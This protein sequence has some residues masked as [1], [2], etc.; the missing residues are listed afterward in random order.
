MVTHDRPKVVIAGWQEMA[1]PTLPMM[2]PESFGAYW[3]VSKTTIAQI[4]KCDRTTVI[5][6]IARHKKD[7]T[8]NQGIWLTLGLINVVWQRQ[9][10]QQSQGVAA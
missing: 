8:I 4:C 1:I 5:R 9:Q 10:R 3:N 6:S 2:D 7:G